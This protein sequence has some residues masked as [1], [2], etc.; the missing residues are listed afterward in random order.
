LIASGSHTK[1]LSRL[2][3]EMKDGR[4]AGFNY[5]LIPVLTDAIAPDPE[6]ARLVASIRGPHETML[7]TELAKADTLLYRRGNFNGTMDDMICAALLA[8]RDAEISL[9]PGFRWGSSILPGQSITW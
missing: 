7:K 9:S 6:M 8:E 3:I 2:D 5:K 1:F 4:M